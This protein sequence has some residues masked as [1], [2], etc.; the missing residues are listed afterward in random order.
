VKRTTKKLQEA[1]ALLYYSRLR[2]EEIAAKL[3][4]CRDTLARWK[5]RDDFNALY[6]ALEEAS[7][8]RIEAA[9]ERKFEAEM[10]ALQREW[11]RKER[12]WI[13]QFELKYST[14]LRKTAQ[15]SA[16]RAYTREVQPV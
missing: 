13:A 2:D 1:V 4:V 11:D 8:R 5:R 12:E 15:F 3:G 10:A 7:W 14:K 9:Q 16:S 6:D